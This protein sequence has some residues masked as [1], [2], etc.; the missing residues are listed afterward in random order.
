MKSK[1]SAD[2]LRGATQNPIGAMYSLPIKFTSDFGATNGSAQ[3]LNIQPVIPVTVGDWNLINRIILP[4]INTNG[5]IEGTPSIPS[6]TEGS[7]A[8]G[9]GD[10][11]YSLYLSPAKAGKVI[12]GIGPSITFPSA[13][14][15]QLGSG[16]WSAGPSA[17]ILTQPEGWT[18][19]VLGR[20]LWSFAGQS[21]RQNVSQFLLEPFVNYNLSDG[22]YLLT[23]MILT[24]NWYAAPGQQWTVPIGGGVGKLLKIGDQ[25][26]NLKAEA[27]YNVVRPDAAPD[28]QFGF[29]LQFLFPK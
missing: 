5:F 18:I 15:S 9:L 2:D 8:L 27:Y 16:K 28:W 6:G 19:G 20:Q 24:A 26:I 7:G 3:F 17:V 11:N 14:N 13:S 22:W 23:D 21:N 4:L 29:T 1:D 10:I 25:A 12:W